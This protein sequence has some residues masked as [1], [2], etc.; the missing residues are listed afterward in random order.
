MC[1]NVMRLVTSREKPKST[2]EECQIVMADIV[3]GGRKSA[4]NVYGLEITP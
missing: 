2:E 3:I 4:Q 1:S